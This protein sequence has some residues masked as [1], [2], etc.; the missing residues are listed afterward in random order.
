MADRPIY[1]IDLDNSAF[2]KFAETFEKFKG[3]Q[4]K[5][6]QAWKANER[7]IAAAEAHFKKMSAGD[8]TLGKRAVAI[9]MAD[10][11]DGW[12]GAGWGSISTAAK[13]LSTNVRAATG[14]LAKWTGI[15]SV[16]GSLISAGG[17]YGLARLSQNVGRQRSSATALGTTW[18]AQAAASGAFVGI[19]GAGR[20]ISG[21]SEATASQQGMWPLFALMGGQA[22][23]FRGGDPVET[24]ASILPTL[25]S[26]ADQ[27]GAMG[28]MNERMRAM[29]LDRLGVGV[30]T[31]RLLHAL[32][33]EDLKEMI[34]TYRD[35]E[36]RMR[37]SARDQKAMQDFATA[38]E[39]SETSI[40]NLFG[41]NL[42]KFT[43]VVDKAVGLLT[44]V[45]EV[46]GR[47]DGP[48]ADG[49]SKFE[50]G[51]H[52]LRPRNRITGVSAAGP[53]ICGE[54]RGHRRGHLPTQPQVIQ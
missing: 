49:L 5:V 13:L 54:R 24:F 34:S 3:E 19:P 25:K 7:L 12:S 16:V 6:S 53:G 15:T 28:S 39:E 44:R 32:K 45:V 30:D 42:V 21:L 27:P 48:I 43:P 33:P 8:P 17:I 31:M 1:K 51:A 41:R 50:L 38:I 52:G 40:T 37:L 46:M 29:G 36:P 10:A 4:A 14:F 20:I 47:D 35:A 23:I 9:R 2:L 11:M 22:E 18:G 26:V